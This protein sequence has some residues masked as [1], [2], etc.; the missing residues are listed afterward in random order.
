[1]VISATSLLRS[2]LGSYGNNQGRV[3]VWKQGTQNPMVD[4]LMGFYSDLMGY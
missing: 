1:M 3:N 2:I 4:H